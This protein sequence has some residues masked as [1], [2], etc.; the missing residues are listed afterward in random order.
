MTH[1]VNSVRQ[2]YGC[3]CVVFDGY[4]VASVKDQEHTRRS[5][6]A[7]AV[8]IQFTN[9]TKVKIKREDFLTNSNNKT[10]LIAKLAIQLESDG[11]DVVLAKS[12]AD[13]EIVSVAIEVNKFIFYSLQNKQVI[14]II[15]IYY[16]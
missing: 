11:Q 12:D 3:C 2:L 9:E 5:S 4:G 15:I 14:I 13:T 8:E 10:S 7:A 16:Y 6:K 1:H